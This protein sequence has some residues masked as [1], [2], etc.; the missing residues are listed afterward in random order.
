ML[1]NIAIPW[2]SKL[3]II[4]DELFNNN[5]LFYLAYL[6]L[7]VSAFILTK[8]TIGLKVRVVGE[9]PKAADTVGVKRI[10]PSDAAAAWPAELS[11]RW[12]AH[13]LHWA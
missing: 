1:Q 6:L 2:L 7:P 10:L 11:L 13:T 8:T 12:P 3:P 9:N 4:G 5:I